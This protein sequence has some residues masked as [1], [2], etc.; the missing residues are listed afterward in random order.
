MGNVEG[1]ISH[2][3]GLHRIHIDHFREDILPHLNGNDILVILSSSRNQ[4]VNENIDNNGTYHTSSGI[5]TGIIQL[6]QDVISHGIDKPQITTIVTSY[7]IPSP[8]EIMAGSAGD[9]NEVKFPFSNE[10]SYNIQISL[11]LKTSERN[12]MAYHNDNFQSFAL[13]LIL[14]AISTYSQ[15]YG[16]GTVYKGYMVNVSPTNS[17]IYYRCIQL[18]EKLI[19]VSDTEAKLAL[20]KSIYKT[21]SITGDVMALVDSVH[22]QHAT[23][24]EEDK[25][26][27]QIILPVAFLLATNQFTY[28][29]ACKMLLKESNI[30]VILQNIGQSHVANEHN[31]LF[32]R[33]TVQ[34]VIGIDLGGT[35]IR[36]GLLQL[37]DYSLIGSIHSDKII[38]PLDEQ[39]ITTNEESES[40]QMLHIKDPR[41]FQN[42]MTKIQHL[43]VDALQSIISPSPDKEEI[44]VHRVV[45]VGLAQPGRVHPN[46][47]ISSLSNFSNW[48]SEPLYPREYI[49]KALEE[50]RGSYSIVTAPEPLF[51]VVEDAYASLVAEMYLYSHSHPAHQSLNEE[52]GNKG[53]HEKAIHCL[54][55]IGTGVGTSL[56]LSTG[57]LY[58]GSN[59]II[60]GGHSILVPNGRLCNCG[61][62][63][64]V[65]AYIS[66]TAILNR[67]K[68]FLQL[69]EDTGASGKASEV[70]DALSDPFYAKLRAAYETSGVRRKYGGH[71][72]ELM[73]C[74]DVFVGNNVTVGFSD[75]NSTNSTN[76]TAD[77][78]VSILQEEFLFYLS[79]FCINIFRFYNPNVLII[80]GGMAKSIPRLLDRLKVYIAS[81]RWSIHESE[82]CE[83]VMGHASYS[84][85]LGA[86]VASVKILN[87]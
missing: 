27:K 38:T 7:V 13:K 53:Q 39:L 41:S 66:G 21:N 51:H 8:T 29:S 30:S 9:V 5:A 64:C 73:S 80:C 68:A 35:N 33:A 43:M 69:E 26:V 18:I 15:A 19:N 60:E 87:K 67:V 1:D 45:A 54:V 12:R 79:F 77:D 57:D 75:N 3:S 56:S 6:V 20:L 59:G 63:G 72:D 16:K 48:G 37:P 4:L 83:L 82:R 50:V 10:M 11:N 49:C 84:G 86:A 78:F 42:V 31:C 46:N 24:R 74:E 32:D 76:N 70:P 44:I 14:N 40:E 85:V 52:T 62:R 34:V 61:Q 81:L 47:G 71:M 36:V 28:S 22:I 58:T 17:K 2:L 55:T 65:E 23:P 25:C